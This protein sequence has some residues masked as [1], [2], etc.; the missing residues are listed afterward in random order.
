MVKGLPDLVLPIL[1]NCT[2][3]YLYV[4]ISVHVHQSGRQTSEHFIK[5]SLRIPVEPYLLLDRLRI[6]L[7]CDR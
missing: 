3:S 5:Q 6:D 7:R 2:F 4:M 1:M